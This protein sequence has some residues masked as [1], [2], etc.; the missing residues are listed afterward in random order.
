MTN[1]KKGQIEVELG[2][3]TYKCRLT[4]DSLIKI[5]NECGQSIIQLAQK[6]SQAD[7]KIF[8]LSTI[9]RYALRGGGNDVQHKEVFKI[10]EDAGIIKVAGAVANLITATLHDPNQ[11]AEAQGKEQA[12]ATK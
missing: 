1:P 5:E 11:A 9:L 12:V 3:E 2:G 10:I 6:M 4:I 7:V 8:D